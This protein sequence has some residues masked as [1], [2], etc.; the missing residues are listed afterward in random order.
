MKKHK[1][2]AAHPAASAE[3]PAVEAPAAT[4]APEV[5][6][7][8]AKKA[9]RAK[10][11]PKDK[12]RKD[13]RVRE[14]AAAEGTGVAAAAAERKPIKAKAYDKALKELHV[15]LVKLQQWV[16]QKGLKVCIIFEGRDGAGK[17]GPTSLE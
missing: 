17:G 11:V 14:T 16:V 1:S 12:G 15:E 6:A 9:K 7:M 3:T 10:A 2:N 4:P 8:P 13:H 5:T